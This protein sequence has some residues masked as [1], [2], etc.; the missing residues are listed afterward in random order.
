MPASQ[1]PG[2]YV[3]AVAAGIRNK[4]R[5]AREALR[6]GLAPDL[7]F[8]AQPLNVLGRLD[9]YVVAPC[10]VEWNASARVQLSDVLDASEQNSHDVVGFGILEI[11]FPAVNVS[12]ELLPLY[13][14]IKV[15][16][17]IP[18][19]KRLSAGGP[20]VAVDEARRPLLRGRRETIVPGLAL[21][22][23]RTQRAQDPDVGQAVDRQGPRLALEANAN[24]EFAD[25]R[26]P[27]SREE[28]LKRLIHPSYSAFLTPD[29]AQRQ[30]S[31]RVIVRE[32][33]H[34]VADTF[35]LRRNV[36]Q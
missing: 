27:I 13:R 20:V 5:N 19:R 9:L 31:R 29:P 11:V 33:R 15:D 1:E 36:R 4:A 32:R 22:S 25:T 26:S 23:S 12:V 18:R 2:R 7:Q 35:R 10:A 28:F 34:V 24:A 16:R 14:L 30:A 8:G 21:A 6:F 3:D 17:N